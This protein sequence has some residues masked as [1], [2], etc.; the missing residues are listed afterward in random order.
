MDLEGNFIVNYE[1]IDNDVKRKVFTK[2]NRRIVQIWKKYGLMGIAIVT[3][4]FLSIPI[5]TIIANSLEA[6]KKKILLYMF[7]SI[8]FWSVAMITVFELLH[9]ASIKDL[10][11]QVIP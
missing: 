8:L 5:G 9:V 6:R 7:F 3:P 10:Q 1:Y 2:K 4:I 11:E